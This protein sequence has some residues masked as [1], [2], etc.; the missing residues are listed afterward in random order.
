M[1]WDGVLN[2]QLVL[3]NFLPFPSPPLLS[4]TICSKVQEVEYGGGR[5][6]AGTIQ[7]VDVMHCTALH[8]RVQTRARILRRGDLVCLPLYLHPPV[9]WV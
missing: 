9:S 7:K 3:C 8:C 4:A 5:P 2:V 6:S 1:G